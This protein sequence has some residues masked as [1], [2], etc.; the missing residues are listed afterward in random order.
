MKEKQL[1]EIMSEVKTEEGIKSFVFCPECRKV[2]YKMP[3]SE[4]TGI[5]RRVALTTLEGHR[6]LLF[7]HHPEIYINST[8]NREAHVWKTYLFSYLPK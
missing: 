4:I 2:L 5:Y 1:K 3:V 8:I 6:F 7:G